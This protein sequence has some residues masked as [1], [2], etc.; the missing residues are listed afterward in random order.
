MQGEH[1]DFLLFAVGPREVAVLAVEQF[2]V[3]A[4]PGLDDLQAFVDLAAQRLAGEVLA[5]EDRA[6][7]AAELFEGLIGGVF[8]AAPREAAQD[9]LGLGGAELQRGG[10]LDAPCVS[11]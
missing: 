9:L 11:V 6:G 8:G 10:V 5:D 3:G 4:V 2:G 1:R 7:R